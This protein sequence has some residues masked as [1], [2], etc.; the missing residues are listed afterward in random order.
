MLIDPENYVAPFKVTIRIILC[1]VRCKEENKRRK[2][3]LGVG[4]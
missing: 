3:A 4:V 2:T 1:E